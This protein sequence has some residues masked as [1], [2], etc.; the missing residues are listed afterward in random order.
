ME[1]K[2][3]KESHEELINQEAERL[4][5]EGKV[6]R[7]NG[8]RRVNRMWLWLG[9]LILIF[10]LV[11]WLFSIGTFEAILGTTNG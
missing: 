2:D 10:I 6:R 4:R 11:Y 9:V 7:N 8:T 5:A 3:R 1:N